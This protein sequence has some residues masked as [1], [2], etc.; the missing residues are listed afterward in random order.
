MADN[1]QNTA[2]ICL[3][4]DKLIR[5]SRNPDT[6]KTLEEAREIIETLAATLD[7]TLEE[8]RY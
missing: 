3:K 8:I 7:E 2:D 5:R 1:Y 4:L 6:I